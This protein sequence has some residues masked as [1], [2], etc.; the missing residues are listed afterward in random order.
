MDNNN[1]NTINQPIQVDIFDNKYIMEDEAK[2]LQQ[3][4]IQKE[5]IRFPESETEK[6]TER[7]RDRDPMNVT[8]TTD[9]NSSLLNTS[10]FSYA[11][12]RQN[13]PKRENLTLNLTNSFRQYSNTIGAG[14]PNKFD[15]TQPTGNYC[16]STLPIRTY[17]PNPSLGHLTPKSPLEFQLDKLASTLEKTRK[18][19]NV[20][21]TATTQ[22]NS[23]KLSRRIASS[24]PRL[25]KA[26]HSSEKTSRTQACT[27]PSVNGNT[28][29]VTRDSLASFLHNPVN[30]NDL[31]V[32]PGQPQNYV[33]NQLQLQSFSQTLPGLP[34]LS[35]NSTKNSEILDSNG[36][37]GHNQPAAASTSDFN[38]HSAAAIHGVI[39]PVNVQNYQTQ[40]NSINIYNSGKFD[41]FGLNSPDSP[42]VSKVTNG[43]NYPALGNYTHECPLDSSYAGGETNVSVKF[44]EKDESPAL[45]K[46]ETSLASEIYPFSPILNNTTSKGGFLAEIDQGLGV[47]IRSPSIASSLHDEG[48]DIQVSPVGQKVTPVRFQHM[49]AKSVGSDFLPPLMAGN[50]S[51]SSEVEVKIGAVERD[52]R[53]SR[54]GSVNGR[55]YTKGGYGVSGR[56]HIPRMGAASHKYK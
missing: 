56:K 19:N 45:I 24:L 14:A 4:Y 30:L 52:S 31:V 13:S 17:P 15:P 27:S 23:N 51:G 12:F 16:N 34:N 3:A 50:S 38:C 26:R 29:I 35:S 20:N 28:P 44:K 11:Q 22:N 54:K 39:G 47:D 41:T 18:L 55:S 10:N 21:S 43:G 37:S 9:L 49:S 6:K 42:R 2:Q 8:T 7:D 53:V 1:N 32:R 48:P 46:S 40:I 25:K 5:I 33:H 36:T